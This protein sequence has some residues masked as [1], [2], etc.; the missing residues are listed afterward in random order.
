MSQDKLTRQ[1]K[2]SNPKE[3]SPESM[4]LSFEPNNLRAWKEWFLVRAKTLFGPVGDALA[5]GKLPNF[6]A[7]LLELAS[8]GT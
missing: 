2:H 1:F 7:I 5:D 3:N 4:M 8:T 6:E